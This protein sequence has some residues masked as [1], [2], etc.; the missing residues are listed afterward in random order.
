MRY[1]VTLGGV[2]LCCG[3]YAIFHKTIKTPLQ[4][5]G[6]IWQTGNDGGKLILDLRSN[7]KFEMTEIDFAKKDTQVYTGTWDLN[8]SSINKETNKPPDAIF[9]AFTSDDKELFN[10]FVVEIDSKKMILQDKKTQTQIQL[11]H[12]K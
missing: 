7:Y 4:N 1:K 2:L 5:I 9:I 8:G 6:G 10:H 11:T 12:N 3:L